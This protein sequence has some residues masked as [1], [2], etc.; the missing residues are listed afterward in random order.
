MNNLVLR[1]S[2]DFGD[3]ISATFSYLRVHFKSLG[4]GLLFF[5]LPMVILAVALIGNA[6]KTMLSTQIANGD[7]NQFVAFSSQFFL[8]VI[9]FMVTFVV[10]SLV[11]L[12][13]M[14]LVDRG[15]EDIDMSMLMEDFLRNFFGLI[16]LFVVIGTASFIG[17]LA[18]I[19]PGFYVSVK[20]SLAPAI[21]IIEGE[22]FGEALGK[23]WS[24]TTD[25]W[26]HT[27]GVNFVVSLIVNAVS[28]VVMIPLYILAIIFF[29][30]GT[31]S[32]PQSFASIFSIAYSLFL[33]FMALLY[34][35]P[36]ISQGL[37]YF[38]LDERKS[39]RGLSAKIDSLG[40]L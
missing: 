35:V 1:Q 31:S 9:V 32:D 29:A 30:S 18:L 17:A 21:F 28:Y 2:R 23:S 40:S 5:S 34:F 13:H 22:D 26:W 24:L 20:L 4:K 15:E 11:V 19:I 10:I 8:G 39:G 38:N 33:T 6:F 3:V 12:K 14:Q 25:F 27:F 37:V 16:G 7:P 36:I